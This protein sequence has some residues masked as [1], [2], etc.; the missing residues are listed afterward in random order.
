MDWEHNYYQNNPTTKPT[1]AYYLNVLQY[2]MGDYSPADVAECI[3]AYHAAEEDEPFETPMPT[4]TD[5]NPTSLISQRGETENL[6]Q[7]RQAPG[8]NPTSLILQRSETAVPG[9]SGQ[10]HPTSLISQR[11]DTAILDRSLQNPT[12]QNLKPTI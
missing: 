5:K 8:K 6:V 9:Q 12:S 4:P 10:L 2:E 11:S 7:F 1:K 3:S